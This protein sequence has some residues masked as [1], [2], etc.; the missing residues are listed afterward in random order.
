[1]VLIIFILVSIV[2]YIIFSQTTNIK[3]K[4]IKYINKN[5]K[6]WSDI[7]FNNFKNNYNYYVDDTQPFL[8]ISDQQYL[9][10]FFSESSICSLKKRF[11]APIKKLDDEKIKDIDINSYK[12][13][14]NWGGRTNPS[15]K[16][17]LPEIRNQG[18][19]CGSCYAFAMTDIISAI[20]Y[21][22][23]LNKDI[24]TENIK[25]LSVQQIIDCTSAN[26]PECLSKPNR[27]CE[28]GYIEQTLPA[29]FNNEIYLS[30]ESD[31]SYISMDQTK[32]TYNYN[33][34]K[35]RCIS[36]DSLNIQ[37]KYFIPPLQVIEISFSD[38]EI[39][40][41]KIKKCL[42]LY[43]PLYIV[44][45]GAPYGSFR[46]YK[47]KD[48]NTYVKD[49]ATLLKQDDGRPAHSLHAMILI[50][51]SNVPENVWLIRNSWGRGWGFYGL[52]VVKQNFKDFKE[53]YAV[54]VIRPI[55]SEDRI[56]LLELV[57]IPRITITVYKK[58]Y[59]VSINLKIKFD[60]LRQSLDEIFLFTVKVI[61]DEK[62]TNIL[63]PDFFTGNTI[64]VEKELVNTITKNKITNDNDNYY[65]M[66]TMQT[67][68]DSKNGFLFKGVNSIAS[69]LYKDYI[70]DKPF[71]GIW[72][73]KLSVKNTDGSIISAPQGVLIIEWGKIKIEEK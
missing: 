53:I 71:S 40:V 32:E 54:E 6:T 30:F 67:K 18:V 4:Y 16:S 45:E 64:N 19:N 14:L 58:K 7:G 25:V 20:M 51:W 37:Y 33:D 2:L 52:L 41:E 46:N 11:K 39:Y 66:Y 1:M 13:K 17:I 44:Y 28:G 36:N 27:G 70:P 23:Y 57:G 22:F 43:G 68:S 55:I 38:S 21:L 49:D 12:D 15:E 26:P 3:Q 61:A 8:D 5:K 35:K 60:S 72:E 9:Q 56:C 34:G 31:Y 47:A 65:N 63:I 48:S 59:T 10:L 73:I 24:K 69:R 42:L 29:Y 50:G 62:N